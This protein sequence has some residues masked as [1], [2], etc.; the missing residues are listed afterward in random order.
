MRY[1]F[2]GHWQCVDGEGMWPE[3]AAEH[4]GNEEAAKEFNVEPDQVTTEFGWG[5]RL[6][7]PGY[8]DCTDWIGPFSTEQEAV[9]ELYEMYGECPLTGTI[10]VPRSP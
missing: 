3:E 1:T 8:M 9:E 4:P 2:H 10:G 6:S 5:A 7:A